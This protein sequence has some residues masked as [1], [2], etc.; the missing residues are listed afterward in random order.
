M[1][2][3]GC[4]LPAASQHDP[5]VA[6]ARQQRFAY[7]D[8]DD[9]GLIVGPL[10]AMTRLSP[11]LSF[12]QRSTKESIDLQ[13]WPWQRWSSPVWALS[14]HSTLRDLFCCEDVAQGSLLAS[15][16]TQLMLR[17][18]MPSSLTKHQ[19]PAQTSFS[20]FQ[21]QQMPKPCPT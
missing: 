13:Q 4:I 21:A 11:L 14:L 3:V 15:H 12:M 16:G 7:Y 1:P 6:T 5:E 19:Y 10:I 2:R 8:A 17:L 9:Q 20:P 18:D